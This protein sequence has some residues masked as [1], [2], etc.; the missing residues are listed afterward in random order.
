MDERYW[1][2]KHDM[3]KKLSRTFSVIFLIG[4]SLIGFG[5]WFIPG[6]QW[7][8][9]GFGIWLMIYAIMSIFAINLTKVNEDKNENVK[10]HDFR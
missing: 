10:V 3:I 5:V 9:I 8:L 6:L 1:I 4:Y 7:K 2:Q